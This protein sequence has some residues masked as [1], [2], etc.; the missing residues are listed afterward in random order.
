M[1]KYRVVFK[2]LPLPAILLAGEGNLIDRNDAYVECFGS[3]GLS[4][5]VV[6]SLSKELSEF[7]V[8]PLRRE[9]F[10]RDIKLSNGERIFFR[11]RM[12]KVDFSKDSSHI[13][14][15]LTDISEQKRQVEE[16]ERLAL[17]VDSSD[18][19]IISISL[20][21]RVMSWNRGAERIYGY[22]SYNI[23]ESSIMKIVPD[24][25]VEDFTHIMSE[26]VSGKSF[27]RY[28]TINCHEDG[29][30][31][32]VSV[33]LSPLTSQ[34][35]ISGVTMVSRDI[36]TRRQAEEELTISH[37]RLKSMMYETV[38][39]LS[40]AHEKRDLY[41]SGHQRIVSMISCCIADEMNLP[42]DQIESLRIA[43][44]LHDIGKVCIPMAILS[45]PSV[46][47]PEE[48]ALMKKHPEAGYEIVK[49]IPFAWPVSDIILQHHERMDGSGYPRGI[50][51]KDI[52]LGAR[53]LAVA[54]VLEAMSAHRPYRPAMGLEAAL[55][56]IAEN[57]GVKYDQ[58]VCNAALKLF[59]EGV[60]RIEQS[61]LVCSL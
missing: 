39:S 36:S 57:A 1:D 5:L 23:I 48:M 18:D 54:D 56:E 50:S 60:L 29:H 13:I 6:E 10:E 20:K 4:G 31:F 25:V 3:D 19:A 8:S 38:E 53:I 46:L 47:S 51:G 26:V 35:E 42:H 32:P 41:T 22:K 21:K 15:M 9:L 16:I 28:E 45:K 44:L 7:M 59:D 37:R 11:I 61:K 12:S 58:D 55:N 24:S 27:S 30:L 2:E 17:I 43:G 34:G 40:T 14:I 52:L 33:T 49:N